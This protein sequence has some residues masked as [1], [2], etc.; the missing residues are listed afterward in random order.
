MLIPE[1][2]IVIW[3][4]LEFLIKHNLSKPWVKVLI[5]KYLNLSSPSLPNKPLAKTNSSYIW[6]SLLQ[7]WDIYK[8]VEMLLYLGS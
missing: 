1:S 7:G 6:K 8:N 3:P 4:C 2:F 5:T